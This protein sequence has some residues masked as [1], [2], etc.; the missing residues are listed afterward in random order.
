MAFEKPCRGPYY[1]LD[2]FMHVN[3]KGPNLPRDT[4]PYKM[5]KKN[6]NL[7][8]CKSLWEIIFFF[9]YLILNVLFLL[10]GIGS[11]MFHMSL[12]WARVVQYCD[13]RGLVLLSYTRALTL[14]RYT[15][16]LLDE[17]PMVWGTGYMIYCMHMVNHF[18][19]SFFVVTLFWNFCFDHS[20]GF[21]LPTK[22]YE[23]LVSVSFTHYS[24]WH[25]NIVT[26]FF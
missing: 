23:S 6:S 10:V 13:A 20:V 25:T 26:L 19:H 12:R 17:L 4:V 9:R 14:F 24:F 5:R 15:M 3:T 11:W 2:L 16:Q 22:E 21:L 7:R 18:L 1:G 8:K